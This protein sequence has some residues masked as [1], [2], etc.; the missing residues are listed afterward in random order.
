MN[1]KKK[2]KTFQKQNLI[3]SNRKSPHQKTDSILQ[4]TG[5]ESLV[6]IFKEG[7]SCHFSVLNKDFWTYHLKMV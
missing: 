5:I 7:N 1:I 2:K 3:I 6:N 4:R